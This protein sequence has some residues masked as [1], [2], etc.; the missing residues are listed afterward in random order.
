MGSAEGVTDCH[1]LIWAWDEGGGREEGG[2]V[3]RVCEEW[4]SGFV[5]GSHPA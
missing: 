1:N 3:V 5:A 2:V 4:L